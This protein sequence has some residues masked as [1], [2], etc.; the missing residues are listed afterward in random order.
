[1]ST[2]KNSSTSPMF[3]SLQYSFL[4][5]SAGKILTCDQL[6]RDF[7]N[8]I[9]LEIFYE[10]IQSIK[11]NSAITSTTILI[12]NTSYNLSLV[13][14]SVGNEFSDLDFQDDRSTLRSI[15]YIAVLQNQANFS[16][17]YKT[18]NQ[19][20]ILLGES[21]CEIGSLMDYRQ[22]SAILEK[23][24]CGV[25][26]SDAQ[27]VGIYA[28]HVYSNA[29]GLAPTDIIGA[30]LTDL[31]KRGMLNPLI[32]PT[33]LKTGKVMTAMQRF[34]TGG[35]GIIS[36]APIYDTHGKLILTITC[37]NAIDQITSVYSPDQ[38]YEANNLSAP[39]NRRGLDNP[40]D[41][42]A[43]SPA[44]KAVVQDAIKVAQHDVSVLILG[45][46]GVG[47]EVITTIIHAASPRKSGRFV[48]INCSAITPSL[49]ESELFGYEPGSFTGALSKGK[50][51]LFEVADN[52]T[53]LLDEIGDMP[54]ELQSKLLRVLQ[55]KEIYRVGGVTPIKVNVRVIAA[56]NKALDKMIPEGKFRQ[57]LYYRLNVVSIDVPPLRNRRED[58]KPL[59]LHFNYLYNKKYHTDK[60]FSD[61]L[62]K[63]LE[64]YP[65][66]GNIRELQNVVERLTV[67]C[68]EHTLLPEHFYTKY[69]SPA[70]DISY[71]EGVH[72][73][74]MMFLKDA[75]AV[76]EK[77]LVTKAM[78]IA[79]STR[80]AAEL[81]DVS[82]S[83]IMRKIKEY[84]IEVS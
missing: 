11:I 58:V 16:E 24:D 5:D 6:G 43:K 68:L 42:I 81:L 76:V 28:N 52:G 69:H 67:L 39:V 17:V 57:D 3:S 80:G 18:L 46:S 50:V 71:E 55:D 22:L 60:V 26:I 19:L 29:T 56:T 35:A 37:V 66:P 14:I 51:G 49:L 54:F 13:P 79:G 73:S 65:W 20:P 62:I 8:K 34:G 31:N 15:A 83:T 72:V 45:E 44:M 1:M 61:A 48:K 9:D 38:T 84:E 2:S 77:K 70:C 36:G 63:S 82:Q 32:T 25:Y 27:G 41:I 23:M 21:G 12:G 74:K 78:E 33:I 40:I 53:L 47:K 10:Q 30:R 7:L 59:L 75:M 4:I 64:E